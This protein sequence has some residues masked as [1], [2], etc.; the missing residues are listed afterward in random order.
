M[1]FTTV[2]FNFIGGTYQSRSR[3]LSTQ[4][5]INM[6]QQVDEKG[7]SP[8]ALHSFPGQK[9]ISQVD[10][11][12]DRGM[13]RMNE[14]QYRVVDKSLY[15]VSP[16]GI[17]TN[18]G[19]I[20]GSGRCIFADDGENLAIISDAVYIYNSF[21]GV[22]SENTNGNLQGVLS[23]D[24]INNQFIYTTENLSFMAQPG[25]PFNVSGLDA[26]GAESSPDK[27]VRDYVFNQTVYR[28]GQRT[29]EPWYNSGVGSPPIDRI[30]GQEISVGIGAIHSMANTDRALYWLGDDKAIYRVA[31]G[32][33]ERVSDDGI[34]NTIENMTTIDD[35]FGYTFTLQGQDFYLITFPSENRT[36]VINERLGANGWFELSSGVKKEGFDTAYSGTSLLQVYN[37]LIVANGGKLLELR[38][39][40]YTQDTDTASRQRSGLPITRDLIPSR[41]RGR[42]IKISRIEFIMETGVG[43]ISG[44]GVLPRMRLELSFDGGRSWPHS[45]W[46]DVGRMGQNTLKAEADLIVSGDEITPRI[47]MTDPVPLSIYSAN[48]DIKAVAR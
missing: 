42:R 26:I 27:L 15:E 9:L 17:H 44:Q 8:F 43:L 32:I 29:I 47:T 2:P 46:V 23:V 34:S 35:A 12:L 39:D 24:I 5:T 21:T 31:G 33:N 19:G 37:K 3:P 40:E 41:T 18:K 1:P 36:F 45:Q 4:R 48:V 16:T 20:V 13:H 22:L 10:G 7:K 28:C 30:E 38:L 6:Y 25:Q 11:E 14:V